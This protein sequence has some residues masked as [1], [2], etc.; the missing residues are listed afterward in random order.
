[1]KTV[2][3]MMVIREKRNDVKQIVSKVVGKHFVD[4][5]RYRSDISKANLGKWYEMTC[6]SNLFWKFKKELDKKISEKGLKV[7]PMKYT[8]DFRTNKTTFNIEASENGMKLC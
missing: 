3:E 1:M 7:L 5:K 6:N 8:T 4:C 2:N